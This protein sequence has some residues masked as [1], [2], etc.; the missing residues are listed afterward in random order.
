MDRPFSIFALS[1]MLGI[2][3]AY[4]INLPY[5][6]LIIAILAL[7][8]LYIYRLVKEK[9][10]I[11]TI[12]FIFLFLGALITK[13]HLINPFESSIGERNNYIGKIVDTVQVNEDYSSYI[14]KIEGKTG[15][16]DEEDLKLDGKVRLTIRGDQ[17]LS[18]GDRIKVQGSLALP[19]RNTNPKLYNE[20]LNFLSNKIYAKLNAND[21]SV[22]LIEKNRELKYKLKED[23]EN[24]VTDVFHQHLNP[25]NSMLI[26]SI[27][28]SKSQLLD[29]IT[30]VKYREL[31][32][33]HIIAVSGTHIGIIG[34]FIF[35]IL[36]R[37]GVKRSINIISTLI[38]L[39]FY[40]YLI[41]FK[42]SSM[43]ALIMYGVLMYSR[44]RHQPYDMINS[45][46][47]SALISLFINP[48]YLFD[49]GFQL[50]YMAV[51]SIALLYNK[52]KDSF[53]PRNNSLIRGLSSVIAVNLGLFPIQSFYFNR[54][55]ILS[56]LA[57]VLLLP[58]LSMAIVIAMLLVLSSYS[59]NFFNF[60]LGPALNFLLNIEYFISEFIYKIPLQTITIYS[61]SFFE[62]ILYYS[63]I[64]FLFN[65][66]NH[67]WLIQYFKKILI[68]FALYCML[69]SSLNIYFDEKVDI[70][71]IDVG[72][73]DSILIS[74]N[75]KYYL[76][77]TGGSL[78]ETYNV[79]EHITVPFLEKKGVKT[80]EGVFITHFDLDHYQGLSPILDNI[81]VKNL[82]FSYYPEDESLKAKINE[83]NIP[84][85]LLK[86]GD[87]LNLG[88]KVDLEI[89]WP[90]ANNEGLSSNNRSIVSILNYNNHKVLFTGD[91][92]KEVELELLGKLEEVDV[93][94]VAHHGSKTSTRNEFLSSVSPEYSIISVG[95]NNFYNHPNEDV[96]ERL[97][98]AGTEIYRTDEM[99]FINIE[100]RDENIS[101]E[102]FMDKSHEAYYLI[103]LLWENLNTI[104]FIVLYCVFSYISIRISIIHN[105]EVHI[106]G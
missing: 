13:I 6:V 83:K 31:G 4:Y 93:L 5:M 60:I 63:I 100:L 48:F 72:Q 95:R 92:E 26:K 17:S 76:M 22:E 75:N 59:F 38:F 19:L 87:V 61:P 62:F 36:S 54:I 71:F 97:K 82:F 91:I 47:A 74:C 41:G 67:K 51:L 86:E 101:I 81:R 52:I 33:A 103:P 21:Y 98:A 89:L 16:H 28:L 34:G 104:A 84:V 105:Q 46:C 9:G 12:V 57:N 18:L 78:S 25:K 1:T 3:I 56:I 23:F 70:S 65:M 30:L 90:K 50:S 80:L 64:V 2:I 45:I 85:Y 7:T 29:E 94:K 68:Y 49:V 11:F 10:N 42:P 24:K 73:G 27:V 58:I 69:I 99:G 66:A 37:F 40:V 8:F 79:G 43:R 15:G 102:P 32:L 53:Y 77:D 106:I 96:I 55:Y 44:V 39:L 20:K 14:F 35:F 88:S